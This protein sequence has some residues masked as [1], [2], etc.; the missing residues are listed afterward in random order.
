MRSA[1]TLTLGLALAT[2]TACGDNPP[3][4]A[5]AMNDAPTSTGASQAD[6]EFE[7]LQSV[8]PADACSWLTPEKL[9]VAFPGLHFDVHQRVE[10]RLSGYTWDS[11]CVYW[12]GVGTIEFAKDAPTHTV[13]IFL[14][15]VVSDAKA[16]SNLASRQQSATTTNGYAPQPSLGA[17]AYATTDTAMA[18]LFFV[19]GNS[20]VQLNFSEL[21]STNAAKIEK[22]LEIARAL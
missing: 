15:T 2:L 3:E 17:N 16:Q 5:A 10:P 21:Q 6:A 22:L 4:V 9:A 8:T 18:R 7:Q 14:N 11:R 12:A 20:E 1:A 19:K 13:E